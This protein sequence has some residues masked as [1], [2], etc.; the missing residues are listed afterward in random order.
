MIVPENYTLYPYQKEGLEKIFSEWRKGVRSVLFQMP[1]GTGKTILFAEIVKMGFQ[2]N[3]KVLIVVHRTEL[4]A[5]IKHKLMAKGVDAGTILA[6]EPSDYTKNI[7][8]ASLQTLVRREHPKADLI[9]IDECHHATAATYKN[10]WEIYPD[11]RFLGVSATPRRLNGEGFEGI[12][13][14]LITSMP[15]RKFI[16]A[17]YLS[18]VTQYACE[19]PDLKD[20][21]KENNDY[22]TDSLAN[23]MMDNTLMA[24]L[25]ESYQQLCMGKSMIVFA[26][27]VAHSKKIAQRY[28]DAGIIAAHIDKTT[29][30]GE[31]EKILDD[32]KNRK[33]QVVSN[34]EIITEGFDFPECEAVQLARPTKSLTLYLQ[35]AGR[36]MRKAEGKSE[37]IILDNAGLW[38]EH[39]LATMDREWTLEG[40]KKKKEGTTGKNDLGQQL[41][42][43]D[44]GTFVAVSKERIKEVKGL[45]LIPVIIENQN[46]L[47]FEKYLSE[48]I[49]KDYN[50]LYA[51]NRYT[52]Y[53]AKSELNISQED[54]EYIQNR[55]NQ[56]NELRE[57]EKQFNIKYWFYA[58]Q[59]LPKTG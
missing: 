56:F 4:V 32:F 30:K 14:V 23:V 40:K 20:V 54:F 27:D 28:N 35:M 26:V 34:V 12:F 2:Q 16:Q 49:R 25:V 57:P 7:Q 45:R 46:L 9:I 39:G 59:R 38:L 52:E 48:A 58:E 5:Q 21:K 37:G 43:K 41:A 11:A 1:T 3:R 53:L 22:E 33:I 50:L 51:Y 6:G 17:G 8:V 47:M 44:D 19:L 36:V 24:D 55:L 42:I 15:V 13:E 29:A 31:R 18:K 10:L